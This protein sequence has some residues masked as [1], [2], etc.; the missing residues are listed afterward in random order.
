MAITQ[1]PSR[2]PLVLSV[3][4]RQRAN[5]SRTFQTKLLT[6]CGPALRANV[7]PF[8][9]EIAFK[10]EKKN[11]LYW[12]AQNSFSRSH[13]SFYVQFLHLGEKIIV[14]VRTSLF[15]S[16]LKKKKGHSLTFEFAVGHFSAAHTARRQA[17]RL[18]Q[19]RDASLTDRSR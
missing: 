11:M 1:H 10:N 6:I 3:S 8:D 16:T 14:L 4:E 17:M 2:V 18:M 5:H 19:G 13:Q 12:R 9:V 7:V 15:R